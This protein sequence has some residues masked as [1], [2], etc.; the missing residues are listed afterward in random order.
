MSAPKRQK[1]LQGQAIDVQVA[2]S[3]SAVRPALALFPSAQPPHKTPY[4]LYSK[5]GKAV[6]GEP[7][8]LAGETDDIEFE[9]R[10]HVGLDGEEAGE[11]E[12]Y[13][14]QYMIGVRNS[15]TNQLTLH[16]APL[17]T[18]TPS[19]K[20]LKSSSSSLTPQQL[21]TAQKAALGSAFGTKKAIKALRAQERNKLNETSFGT[22]AHT[23]GLQ[24]HLASTIATSTA[25]LPTAQAVEDAA[26][27]SRPIP[28]FNLAA[29]S[30]N[31][32]YDLDA[33]VTPAE[34]NAFDLSAFITDPGFKERNARL[35]YRRA[36][37]IATKLR[38]I[39]PARASAEGAVP[40]P[41]KKERER[42]KLVIHLSYLFAFRQAARS[43]PGGVDRAKV[44]E[45]LGH[46]SPAVV[47]ALMERYTEGTRGPTGGEIRKVTSVMELKLL[48]Y[49]LVVVLKIDGWSTDVAAIADDLGM[50]QKKVQ[51]LFRSLGCVLAAPSATDRDKAVATGQAATA[52]EAAKSRRAVLKVPLSFPK[53]RKG[54]AKR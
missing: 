37:F 31:D 40:N 25:N 54:K 13:S 14:V 9:S 3:S 6:E 35:P 45:K 19:I 27:E 8:V 21:F 46:P 22:G 43:G 49:L 18:F 38:Q 10:N 33:V 48:A 5:N 17:H 12:G 53:E 28:P 24:S 15:R 32:V 52:A 7:A 50:G 30:P 20:S 2:S 23:A 42:L 36:H 1:G 4:T 47:D 16:A 41:T 11:S 29:T 39:L 34:L 51:E 44:V 26:N